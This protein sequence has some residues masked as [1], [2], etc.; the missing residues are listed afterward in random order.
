M[1]MKKLLYILLP[2]FLGLLTLTSCDKQNEQDL[3]GEWELLSKPNENYSYKW[4]FNGSK[5]TLLA[6]NVHD[7]LDGEFDTC[8]VANYVMKNGVITV[9]AADVWCSYMTY[10]GEWDIQKLEPEFMTLRHETKQG[11]LWY[12]FQK[13]Q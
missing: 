8:V 6:T 13:I 9:A 2:A 3:I 7:P 10:V 12:E 1:I 4:I 11:T 5:V